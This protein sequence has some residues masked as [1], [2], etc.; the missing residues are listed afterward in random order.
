MRF[1]FF[2]FSPAILLLSG[3]VGLI[4]GPP[5]GP[6]YA[7]YQPL[8]DP[9]AEA[10]LSASLEKA[11]EQFGEPVIPVNKVILRRSQKTEAARNYLMPEDISETTCID[12]TN[13][14]FVILIGVDPDHRN[15]YPLLGHECMHLLNPHITD[16]YMEGIA[17]VFSE[18]VCAEHEKDWGDWKRHFSRTRRDPYALSYRMMKAMQEAFPDAYPQLITYAVPNGHAAPWLKIDIDAWLDSLPEDRREEALSI[19]EPNVGLL[20]RRT[21]AQYGFDV[22]DALK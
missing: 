6:V 22:P 1:L 15:Y 18:Q 16:W 21:N 9:V 13:G 19:I 4:E 17:T 5:P 12:T 7:A 14:V 10:F 20:E 11:K 2:I 3:C 8:D